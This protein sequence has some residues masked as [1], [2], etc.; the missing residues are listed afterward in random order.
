MSA[1]KPGIH[2]TFGRRRLPG[3]ILRDTLTAYAFIG[4]SAVI[5]AVFGLF[6]VLFT[7]FVSLFRWRLA[8]GP[9][10]GLDNYVTLFGGGAAYLAA[11]AASIGGL[12]LAIVLLRAG[13]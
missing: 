11:L 10:S 8:R 7:F 4:P 5:M 1:R 9:F 3:R 2:R 6:P 13:R 12:V